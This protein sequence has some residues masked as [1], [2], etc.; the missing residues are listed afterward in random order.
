VAPTCV[1]ARH[2]ILLTKRRQADEK[3][4][5]RL[6]DKLVLAEEVVPPLWVAGGA[7]GLAEGDPLVALLGTLG[8][9]ALGAFGLVRGYRSTLR[10]YAGGEGAARAESAR[11]ARS[12]VSAPGKRRLVER[13]IPGVHDQTAAVALTTLQS[14]LRAPEIMMGVGFS[15][16]MFP[17]VLVMLGMA[18]HPDAHLR[19]LVVAGVMSM[20]NLALAQLQNNHFGYDRDAFRALLLAPIARRRLLLGKNLAVILMSA[21]PCFAALVASALWVHL[22]PLAM[23]AAVLQMVTMLLVSAMVGNLLSILVPY[24]V[25][26]GSMK[27]TKLPPGAW[28]SVLGT[29][30]GLPILNAPVFAGPLA[31]LLGHYAHWRH[32]VAVD[33]AISLVMTAVVVG[34][35]AASLP[36]VERLLQR[37]ETTILGRVTV[38]HE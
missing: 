25:H 7:R 5:E 1:D 15:L 28:L 30:F 35:H 10:F 8:F 12:E 3:R 33:L 22:P 16:V 18:F 6:A 32:P 24:R 2:A 29:M 20:I 17:M 13:R 38:E 9:A 19:P 23:V 31:V 11:P 36:S 27:A 37:R 26:P 14:I 4:Q 34:A 21:P